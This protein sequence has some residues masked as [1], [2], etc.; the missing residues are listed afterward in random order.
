MLRKI[1][2]YSFIIFV[3]GFS[4]HAYA[5]SSFFR[6]FDTENPEIDS[7]ISVAEQFYKN[8]DYDGALK[9]Y[10]EIIKKSEEKNY[11]KGMTKGYLGCSGVYFT[12]G[13]LDVSTSFLIKARGQVYAQENPDEMYQIS[14]REGLNLHTLGLYDE[15]INKYKESISSANKIANQEERLNKLVGVYINIGDIYQLQNQ[16]DSAFYYYK[17]AYQ[18]PT[19]NINNKFTSSV[20]ISDLFVTKGELDSAQ[21]YLGYAKF[22]ADKLNS[23]YSDALL[24]EING[25]YY[26]ASGDFPNAISAFRQSLY[27]NKKANRPKPELYKFLSETYQKKGNIDASN[28]YLKRY[29]EIKDSLEESRKQNLKVPVLMAKTDNQ[30]KLK[31]AELNT[32]FIFAGAFLLLV[33]I[34]AVV[35]FYVQRQKR[36][37]LK[38]K[39]ENIQLKK[40]LNNAFEEVVDLA[41]TNSPN[42]LSRFIEVY[43]EFY[44]QLTTQYEHLTTADLKLCAMMKLDFSTKEIAEITFSSL[45]TV[46]NRKYKLRKKFGLETDENINQWIQNLHIRSLV[47]V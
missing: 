22:Y 4:G 31:K 17:N 8:E 9:I 44:N 7:L 28:T 40:K 45:R 30:N 39:K 43:P 14:F 16:T 26:D 12:K 27:L 5:G 33:G 34:L 29:V 2:F 19:T 42:F 11:S 25:K 3:C 21:V 36:K 23:D 6:I 10:K 38:G 32:K 1:I 37:S 24:N 20:S 46:Q 18:S 15:A 35:Y 13:K 47:S 41:M